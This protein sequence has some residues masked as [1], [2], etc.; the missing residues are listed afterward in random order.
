M[1]AVFAK[2]LEDNNIKSS[3]VAKA[4]GISNGTF[5][6]WKNGRSN[7]GP[8]TLKKIANYF[9]V[10]VDY[11]ITGKEPTIDFLYSEDNA[12]FLIEIQKKSHNQ[13]FV[14]RIK[15]YMNLI[16]ADQKSVD[17]LIDFLY[18]KEKKEEAD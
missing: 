10:S 17:D 5:S 3:T 4:T 16:E 9:N 18:D 15:K 8:K 7:P 1:Y 6:D 14:D 12:E 13:N 11:L 2:L